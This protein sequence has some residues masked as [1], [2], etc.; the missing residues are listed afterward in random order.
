MRRIAILLAI[1]TITA[2]LFAVP[3]KMFFQGKFTDDVGTPIDGT[4]DVITNIWDSEFGG[5]LLWSDT[6]TVEFNTGLFVQLL[7][8]DTP[9]PDSCFEDGLVKF[10]EII[11]DGEALTRKPLVTVPYA[12]HAAFADSAL[13]ASVNYDTIFAYIDTFLTD[14]LGAY[15]DSTWR[16][17]LDTLQAY[18]DTTFTSHSILCS[19]ITHYVETG[20]LIIDSSTWSDSSHWTGYVHWDSIGGIPDPTTDTNF[21]RNQRE[22]IQIGDFRIS[23]L[24]EAETLIARNRLK[25]DGELLDSIGLPGTS[26]QVLMSTGTKPIWASIP[27]YAGATHDASLIGTGTILDPLGVHFDGSGSAMTVARSDHSHSAV[28]PGDIAYSDSTGAVAWIDIVGIPDPT[29]DTNFIRNQRDGIQTGDFRISGLAEVETLV[30]NAGVELGGVFRTTWPSGA[31]GGLVG[32]GTDN[33]IPRWRG[34]DTLENS[35]L[36][37]SD[38]GNVGIGTTSPGYKLDVNGGM[39]LT[40]PLYD[41]ASLPGTSSQALLSVGTAV[42]WGTIPTTGPVIHDGSLAGD[43]TSPVPLRVNFAGTGLASTASRSD[44]THETVIPGDIAYADSTGAVAWSDITG[45]PAGFA[46]GIDDTSVVS[47]GGDDWGADTVNHDVTLIG[48]GTDAS[49]LSIAPQGADTGQVLKWTGSTWSP[50]GIT[51][52]VDPADTII[53]S[54][55]RLTGMGT[56]GNPLDIAQQGAGTGQVLK[57]DGEA[58]APADDEGSS[59]YADSAG[60]I[61]DGGI[62]WADLSDEVIDSLIAMLD[63]FSVSSSGLDFCGA[64]NKYWPHFPDD[65]TFYLPDSCDYMFIQFVYGVINYTGVYRRGTPAEQVPFLF[66]EYGSNDFWINNIEWQHDSCLN[67]TS[68][69]TAD[70]EICRITAYYFKDVIGRSGHCDTCNYA[71]TAGFAFYAD[72]AGAV[73]NGSIEWSDLSSDLIDSLM[74]LRS[75]SSSRGTWVIVDSYKVA[76]ADI[77]TIIFEDDLE[78]WSALKLIGY[79]TLDGSSA[80]L[81]DSEIRIRINDDRSNRYDH[82]IAEISGYSGVFSDTSGFL[83]YWDERTGAPNSFELDIFTNV[84]N[85][86]TCVM[87]IVNSA[88]CSSDP[89][90]IKHQYGTISYIGSSALDRLDI[91]NPSNR[92]VFRIGTEFILLGLKYGDS[93]AFLVDSASWSMYSDSTGAVAWED[94]IGIPDSVY[95]GGSGSDFGSMCD[96][97]LTILSHDAE[98]SYIP[99]DVNV[100]SAASGQYLYLPEEIGCSGGEIIAL[101]FMQNSPAGAD[102]ENITVYLKNTFASD[103]ITGYDS[104]YGTEVFSGT[105]DLTSSAMVTIEPETLFV[106]E[107]NSLL[108]T[109]TKNGG[110]AVPGVSWWVAPVDSDTMGRYNSGVSGITPEYGILR[111]P[112]VELNTETTLDVVTNVNGISGVVNIEGTGLISVDT[113]IDSNV[114][115]I[116]YDGSNGFRRIYKDTTKVCNT[117]DGPVTLGEYLILGGTL[118]TDL[119]INCNVTR[120]ITPGGTNNSYAE[121]KVNGVV[122]DEAKSS[123]LNDDPPGVLI[124]EI[125]SCSLDSSE[126]D[127]SSD[128][129]VQIIGSGGLGTGWRTCKRKITIYGK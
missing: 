69:T 47:G 106:Y 88:G 34:T 24:G 55:P 23:G 87:N 65:T 126:I 115:R 19:L 48:A 35:V 44:H 114:I 119:L 10:L 85:V 41:A 43:G 3:S 25:I 82:S 7:G 13:G 51:S 92:N 63:T 1:I 97:P 110:S 18:L 59:A 32:V 123:I 99:I 83:G 38:A 70:L 5:E 53:Y 103:L 22:G 129:N 64:F 105:L 66:G 117:W 107:G 76:S 89:G 77:D 120:A 54:T 122:M 16:V 21:I 125:L 113:N 33:Y 79:G 27:P 112:Y 57:W 67:I 4:R 61:E 102:A 14:T 11:V 95:A 80:L 56:S 94:I 127:F 31:G 90:D 8:D 20:S 68:S 84:V 46:D 124:S 128:I 96:G 15:L 93:S 29:T 98:T 26:N 71:D 17:D 42:F 58:W 121:L 74:S 91:Y 60:A 72:S 118:T 9:I 49:L 50:S 81:E 100:T 75:I 39:H 101:S 104:D 40:G 45:M 78:G 12:F 111:R 6:N 52:P 73:I 86:G 2:S 116:K 108:L 28:V 62:D 36:Y 30:A 109:I 37:Q